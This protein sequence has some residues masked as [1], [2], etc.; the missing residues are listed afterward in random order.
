MNINFT[1]RPMLRPDD[2]VKAMGALVKRIGFK[3]DKAKWA[4]IKELS[5]QHQLG[6][7]RLSEVSYDRIKKL[8]I[9][10]DRLAIEA[11][12][13]AKGV[14]DLRNVRRPN[15]QKATEIFA[16]TQNA[17]KRAMRDINWEAF[18]LA[19]DILE[20]FIAKASPHIEGLREKE[21][22]IAQDFGLRHVDSETVSDL[23]NEIE[24]LKQHV[25]RYR[26]PELVG[27]AMDPIKA[28]RFIDL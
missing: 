9:E 1:V 11:L 28:L 12:R 14:E 6:F 26:N 23:T 5:K 18:G 22:A 4:R 20:E 8:Y 19:A 17:M 16:E 27:W 25:Q 3:P 24:Q 21:R 15:R 13:T 7:E 10:T 2:S